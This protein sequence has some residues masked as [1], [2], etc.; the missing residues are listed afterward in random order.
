MV[1]YLNS[2]TYPRNPTELDITQNKFSRTYGDLTKF[3]AKYTGVVPELSQCN[4]TPT[5]WSSLYPFYV[6][7]VSKQSEKLKS[8][9]VD[10]RVKMAF[11]ENVPANTKAYVLLISDRNIVFNSNGTSFNVVY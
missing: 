7:D 6:F 1:V 9:S 2:V 5:E 4:I 10:V 8:G 11:K 3:R